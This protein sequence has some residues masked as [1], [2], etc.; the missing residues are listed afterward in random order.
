MLFSGGAD[1]AALGSASGASTS[2]VYIGQGDNASGG[3]FATPVILTGEQA[4]LAV[5]VPAGGCVTSFSATWVTS[6]L[7]TGSVSGKV[8]AALL[9]DSNNNGVFDLLPGGLLPLN[10]TVTASTPVGTVLYGS[11]RPRG[12]LTAGSR[13]IVAFYMVDSSASASLLGYGTA[14]IGV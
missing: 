1:P 6:A 8:Y 12:I 5:T 9:A 7:P 3:A 10:G 13:V 14:A 2:T 4:A 11:S